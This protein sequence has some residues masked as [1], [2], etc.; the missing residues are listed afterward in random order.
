VIGVRG[1]FVSACVVY[2][3]SAD[4]ILRRDLIRFIR[5]FEERNERRLGTWEEAMALAGEASLAMAGLM[6][7]RSPPDAAAAE[8]A[9]AAN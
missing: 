9:A 4:G 5:E 3:G 7:G 1:Q 6:D 8:L 2:H